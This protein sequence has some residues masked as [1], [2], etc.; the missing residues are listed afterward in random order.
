MSVL[1]CRGP[2][3]PIM[4]LCFS[5]DG[6]E[7]A[8]CHNSSTIHIVSCP[9]AEEGDPAGWTVTATLPT[10]HQ[11]RVSCL[12]WHPTTGAILSCSHDGAAYV[13]VRHDN[14]KE[15]NDDDDDEGN[16]IGNG[17]D[18][19]CPRPC[20]HDKRPSVWLPQIVVLGQAV[21]RG[22]LSCAW[23][24]AGDKL[25]VACASG[26]IAVGRYDGDN[27]WWV[28]RVLFNPDGS[29]N[30][31]GG[32]MRAP[33]V[34][35]LAPHPIDGTL[36]A[37][38]GLDGRLLLSSTLMKKVDGKRTGAADFGAVYHSQSMGGS[39]GWVHAMAWS[40]CGARLAVATH[41]SCLHI[42]TIAPRAEGE[43]EASMAN[44]ATTALALFARR[45]DSSSG[46][47]NA[48]GGVVELITC[49][50]LYLSS[51]PL[52]SLAFV[53]GCG[54]G[55]ERPLL[56][57]AAGYSRAPMLFKHGQPP[58][59]EDGGR[60]STQAE[61]SIAAIGA[62]GVNSG[63]HTRTINAIAVLPSAAGA[64][65]FFTAG[66][67]GQIARWCVSDLVPV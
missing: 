15:E 1:Y 7:A 44:D 35:A 14:K 42:F 38:G 51:L 66:E 48:M 45:H 50:T 65:V 46:G 30:S 39:S 20:R 25:M 23:S 19:G 56:L 11:D 33:A 34:S 32:G 13:W 54:D 43:G 31:S 28:C 61:W 49:Q 12:R 21:A 67:D 3:A 40:G 9:S 62:A 55:G 36:L 57:L 37:S 47:D 26:A 60:A 18:E 58:E 64:N 5:G 52:L 59:E 10:Y 29:S 8:L 6:T 24:P 53:G 16:G 41:D 27:D 63:R 2:D 22:L 4:D 17:T